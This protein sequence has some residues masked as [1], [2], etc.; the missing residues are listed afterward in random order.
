[1]FLFHLPHTQLLEVNLKVHLYTYLCNLPGHT[2]H[3]AGES[4]ILPL[5]NS[6]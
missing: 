5:K 4:G 6:S 3:F 2:L 1:M